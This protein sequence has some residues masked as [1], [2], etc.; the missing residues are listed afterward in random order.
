MCCQPHQDALHSKEILSHFKGIWED[1]LRFVH[2][3]DPRMGHRRTKCKIKY[4]HRFHEA[5][6][7]HFHRTA[8]A[9]WLQSHRVARLGKL[10]GRLPHTRVLVVLDAMIVGNVSLLQHV[11]D[12][13]LI[14]FASCPLALIDVAVTWNRVD[15]A[16]FLHDVGHRGITDY[17]V[18]SA[19]R[20]GIV[21]LIHSLRTFVPQVKNRCVFVMATAFDTAL[22]LYLTDPN[23]V[24]KLGKLTALCDYVA[25]YGHVDALGFLIGDSRTSTVGCH[26]D[27]RLEGAV[28]GD[29]VWRVVPFKEELDDKEMPHRKED[30][31]RK[32]VLNMAGSFAASHSMT[33]AMRRRHI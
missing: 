23:V 2:L 3:D 18:K 6:F 21:G 24:A 30:R 1:M 11:H 32:I 13:R 29:A 7:L 26:A 9:P 20:F 22:P 31:S 8:V 4:N 10:F 14:N 12:A 15:V 27:K 17:G 33:S 5:K 25:E 28:D 16:Q 19:S